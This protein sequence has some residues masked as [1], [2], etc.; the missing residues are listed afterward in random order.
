M[1][2]VEILVYSGDAPSVGEGQNKT[3]VFLGREI[4]KETACERNLLEIETEGRKEGRKE[5][6]KKVR[7]V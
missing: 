2:N 7:K 5:E 1:A 4:Q 6:R 3:A